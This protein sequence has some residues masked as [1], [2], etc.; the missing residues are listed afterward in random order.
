MALPVLMTNPV[1]VIVA[2]LNPLDIS[3]EPANVD[4]AVPETTNCLPIDKPPENELDA[5]ALV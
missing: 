2:A 1:P 3:K 5:V 4:E